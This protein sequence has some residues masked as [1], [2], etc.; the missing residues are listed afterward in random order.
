MWTGSRRNVSVS[1]FV[2][3]T[4][5]NRQNGRKINT[6]GK[7]NCVE[8]A[9]K[10][11]KMAISIRL[12][13]HVW[14][15]VGCTLCL[16]LVR[17]PIVITRKGDEDQTVLIRLEQPQDLSS[18]F[19]FD[20]HGGLSA[21]ASSR[22]LI[23]YPE[24]QRSEILDYL[25]LPNFGASI[26][27]LKLEIGGDTQ[28]TVGTES[29]HQHSASESP[30]CRRGYEGW[31]AREARN[32]NPKIVIWSLSWGVPGWIG[33]NENDYFTNANIEYQIEWLKCLRDHYHVESNYIGLWNEQSQGSVDYVLKLRKRMDENGFDQVGITVEATWQRLID[34]VL[35]DPDFNNSIAAAS[36]HYP[37]NQTCHSALKAHKKLWAGEDSPTPFANWTGASCWGRKLNQHYLRLNATSV[38]SWALV[39]SALEGVSV[40]A[41]K[42]ETKHQFRGSA[43][44]IAEEPWSG[45]YRILPS[46]WIQAHWGQF[47]HPGW[48]Y[49]EHGRGSGFLPAGGSY[50]SL[51]SP[52]KEN[53]V[54]DVQSFT[55]IVETL[56]GSCGDHPKFCDVSA[57]PDTQ[58]LKFHLFPSSKQDQAKLPGTLNVWCSNQTN[59]F[60]KQ[61]PI[62]VDQEDRSFSL[63]V[64]PDTI[65]TVTTEISG[66]KGQYPPSPPSTPFPSSY[67]TD[68]SSTEED[69]VAFGFSDVYGSFA[70]RKNSLTQVATT[71]PIGWAPLNK[72]PLTLFGDVHWKKINVHVQAFVNHT[73]SHHYIRICGG[74][75]S[76][77]DRRILFG[78]PESSCFYLNGTG[79]WNVSNQYSGRLD[80]FM[81]TWHSVDF[82]I[83]GEGS[84]QVALD[85]KILATTPS[86]TASLPG[87]IGIGCGSYHMCAF[88]HF[89]VIA[90]REET[91]TIE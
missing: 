62:R 45:N 29:S 82:E 15:I 21:G 72:D 26:A 89:S 5:N 42:N 73:E 35:D 13:S 8:P 79:S 2:Y 33:S 14:W 61:P 4:I 38:I 77:S 53:D 20:G 52:L 90:D 67:H 40:P 56:Q 68:F 50:I 57:F 71:R 7:W 17:R 65:C 58:N 32:R 55:I 63:T 91:R 59:V 54:I 87:M 19:V 39:W 76:M 70:V 75:R 34:K 24:P 83:S 36:L 6:K 3:I 25:F 48:Y 49:L 12:S 84:I 16:L 74:C 37:C 85:E 80:G 51:V 64:Y 43:F 28:S 60:V 78:C 86:H 88:K 47:V 27:V 31:L 66:Q 41:K 81:D 30:N 44:V 46:L 9:L 10:E 1:F 69:Q 22:L 23:D 18:L 11:I